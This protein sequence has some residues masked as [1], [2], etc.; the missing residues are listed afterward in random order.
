M[1]RC[2]FCGG[3][4]ISCGCCYRHKRVRAAEARAEA[5]E[6]SLAEGEIVERAQATVIS[7]VTKERDNL[8]EEKRDV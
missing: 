5:A 3:Q 8:E 1:E 7:R 4:L 6:Q 2:P